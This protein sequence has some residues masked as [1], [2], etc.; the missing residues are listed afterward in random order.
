MHNEV[1]CDNTIMNSK[2]TKTLVIALLAFFLAVITF[3]LRPLAIDAGLD[4]A[5]SF[6]LNQLFLTHTIGTQAFFTYGPLG[7]LLWPL[8][9]DNNIFI[10]GIFWLSLNFILCLTTIKLIIAFNLEQPQ[11]KFALLFLLVTV[12]ALLLFLTKIS[13]TNSY[14]IL[15]FIVTNFVLLFNLKKNQYQYLI[16]AIIVATIDFLMSPGYALY[17]VFAL[18]TYLVL[19]TLK[20]KKFKSFALL[21]LCQLAVYLLLWLIINHSFTGVINYLSISYQ[22]V[23]GNSDAMSQDPQNNWLALALMFAFIWLSMMFFRKKDFFAPNGLIVPTIFVLT[24]FAFFKYAYGRECHIH[25]LLYFLIDLFLYLL[26]ML[27][28]YKKIIGYIF[29]STIAL[30]FCFLN[31]YSVTQNYRWRLYLNTIPFGGLANIDNI[32]IHQKNYQENLLQESARNL[33]RFRLPQKDLAII[34]HKTVDSYP[35]DLS[36]IAS[37]PNL[38]WAPR[39]ILQSYVSYTPYLDQLNARHFSDPAKAPKYLVWSTPEWYLLW[40]KKYNIPLFSYVPGNGGL[41]IFYQE[42]TP[43]LLNIDFKYTLNAEP[44][45]L[46]QILKWYKL[47]RIN[48]PKY[49]IFA[50]QEKPLLYKPKI[51]SKQIEIWDSWIKVPKNNNDI[52]RARIYTQEK[53]LEKIKRIFYKQG[54]IWLDYQLADGSINT[55]RLVLANA[56]N[57]VWIK[58]YGKFIYEILPYLPDSKTKNKVVAIRIRHSDYDFFMPQIRIEWESINQTFQ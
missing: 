58:P 53:L 31:Q 2:F 27:G 18:Y 48:A 13:D 28:E 46:Y 17:A 42:T 52:L 16:C 32:F 26:L 36:I 41:N 54:S 29:T 3:S 34:S 45:T 38:N 7:F 24:I 33:Q 4:E 1:R 5:W 51:I 25:Y 49:Y 8:P 23:T 12:S 9:I 39:P 30:S 44:K 21:L 43:N 14:L 37:N 19:F 57:G 15:L 22:L 6:A 47:I 11:N 50:R 55:Y 20:Y 40:Y 56:V 10:A 35:D